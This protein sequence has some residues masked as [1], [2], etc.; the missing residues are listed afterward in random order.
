MNNG[1]SWW[2]VL[3]CPESS[4]EYSSFSFSYSIILPFPRTPWHPKAF[5]QGSRWFL[6][7]LIFLCVLCPGAF[8]IASESRSPWFLC[9]LRGYLREK[10]DPR[11]F[12]F[13]KVSHVLSTLIIY[14]LA[15][16]FSCV[17]HLYVL[18][19]CFISISTDL[20]VPCLGLMMSHTV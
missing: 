17:F 14:V 4:H 8:Q 1:K 11:L 10:K 18:A 3:S 12:R 7:R 13:V 6:Q 15:M 5:A 2:G 19:V 16:C 9:V 20:T